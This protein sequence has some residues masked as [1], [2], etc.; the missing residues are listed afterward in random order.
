MSDFKCVFSVLAGQRRRWL[1]RSNGV[2]ARLGHG[3]AGEARAGPQAR[4]A[5]RALA[6]AR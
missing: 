3:R 5:R 4:P 6:L 1:G 2:L